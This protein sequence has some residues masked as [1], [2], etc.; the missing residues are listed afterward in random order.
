M[1]IGSEANVGWE[2]PM[3]YYVMGRSGPIGR[4]LTKKQA[5]DLAAVSGGSIHRGGK[6]TIGWSIAEEVLIRYE[7]P[8]ETGGKPVGTVYVTGPHFGADTGIFS[9]TYNP[10]K[11]RRWTHQEAE[12]ELARGRHWPGAVIVPWVEA[13]D[14]TP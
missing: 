4:D 6:M 7:Y 13:T 3:I 5:K 14:L 11:A 12:R 1:D 8:G 9:H 2:N 10:D